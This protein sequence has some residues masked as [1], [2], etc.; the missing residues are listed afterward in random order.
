MILQILKMD[1][2][3]FRSINQKYH[4]T[5]VFKA[6]RIHLSFLDGNTNGIIFSRINYMY[7][8]I[9][10]FSHIFK[11]KDFLKSHTHSILIDTST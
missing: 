7:H 11:N 6:I 4:D 5:T 9:L 10:G 8:N 2:T 1:D 3:G